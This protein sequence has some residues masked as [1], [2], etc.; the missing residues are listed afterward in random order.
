M[1]VD[2]HAYIN[3]KYIL[4]LHN[5][6]IAWVGDR[7]EPLVTVPHAAASLVCSPAFCCHT[8]LKEMNK[9]AAV[10]HGSCHIDCSTVAIMI[11]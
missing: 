6:I 11:T 3:A 2:L 10:P 5:V 7:H 9:D 1:F 8:E 4:Q